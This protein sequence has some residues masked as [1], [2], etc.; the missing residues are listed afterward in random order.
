[1]ACARIDSAMEKCS[2]CLDLRFDL[3]KTFEAPEAVY[4]VMQEDIIAI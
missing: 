3:Y 4:V 2:L 1:M